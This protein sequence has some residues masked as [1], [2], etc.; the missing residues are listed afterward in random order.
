[1]S[2]FYKHKESKHFFYEKS[3]KPFFGPW[4]NAIKALKEVNIQ[5]ISEEE[6]LDY[7]KTKFFRFYKNIEW[8]RFYNF[9][10][11]GGE[12]K[13]D[14][15]PNSDF[16]FRLAVMY[17]HPYPEI[18]DEFFEYREYIT[19]NTGWYPL[20]Q[21]SRASLKDSDYKEFKKRYATKAQLNIIN[22]SKEKFER[23]IDV[24]GDK[25]GNSVLIEGNQGSI[26][27]DTGFDVNLERLNNVKLVCL[28]H[29]HQDHSNGIWNV[30]R[31]LKVPVILSEATMSYL[32]NDNHIS[33]QEKEIL[34]SNSF[35]IEDSMAIMNKNENIKLFPVFHT[36]GS[37][38]FKIQDSHGSCIYYLGDVCLRNGFLDF[39]EDIYNNIMF[40]KQIN[41]WVIIDAAMIGKS[42]FTIC[43]DDT[44]K[45][46][47]EDITN[48]VTKRNVVFVGNSAEMLIYAYILAFRITRKQR[49]KSIKLL[50]NNNLYRLLKALWRSVILKPTN[51]T[52]P[53]IHSVIGKS[54]SNF[55]ESQRI[56]PLSILSHINDENVIIFATLDDIYKIDGINK[57]MNKADVLLC[58]TLSLRSD[59]PNEISTA[60]PRSILRIAS[61]DWSFH[62]TEKDLVEFI[63]RLSE[64]GIKT[65]L[66]HN[67]PK[68][69]RNFI[70]KNQLDPNHVF[71][72]SKAGVEL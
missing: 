64:T 6:Y 9:V 13:A 63:G 59:I 1:M 52:D 66:Y 23:I 56:Y 67:Y 58:G 5:P 36:P 10:W 22:S 4:K 16:R 41:N 70:R 53:F 30:L 54:K 3:Y 29:F 71:V 47:L 72:N 61:E 62:S 24:S 49:G 50:L 39:T 57:K 38:G 7:L 45:K 42:E 12:H 31:N 43:E 18:R 17:L 28:S 25:G 32:W 65:L 51:L 15:I 11:R 34:M 69:L 26:L 60:R 55:I 8:V 40:E 20:I 44:P 2:Y 33:N 46:V 27:F 48:G 68:T 21:G 14:I 37:Y 35:I 19:S